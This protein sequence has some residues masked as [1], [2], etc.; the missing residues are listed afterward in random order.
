MTSRTISRQHIG[1]VMMKKVKQ[2]GRMTAD[3]PFLFEPT[4]Q[5]AL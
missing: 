3:H 5:Y 2:T 1:G 4:Y